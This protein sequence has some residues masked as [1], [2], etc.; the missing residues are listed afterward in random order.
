M[1][2]WD[3]GDEH[4][5]VTYETARMTLAYNDALCI[6]QGLITPSGAEKLISGLRY[7]YNAAIESRLEDI[8]PIARRTESRSSMKRSGACKTSSV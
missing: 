3:D 2:G 7:L 6:C 1:L 4:E 8:K 5:H